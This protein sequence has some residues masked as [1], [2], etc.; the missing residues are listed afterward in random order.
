MMKSAVSRL[1]FLL[2][3]ALAAF[4]VHSPLVAAHGEKSQESFL[5][6]RTITFY[7]VKWSHD[8]IKVGEEMVITGKYKILENWPRQIHHPELG[9]VNVA[10][11]GPQLIRK[12]VW[13]NGVPAVNSSVW[14]Q[15]IGG[16]YEFRNVMVARRPG[17]YHMHVM[18]SVDGAG[19]LVGPGHWITVEPGPAPFRNDVK[20]L[21]GETVNLETYG[22]GRIFGWHILWTVI[23]LAWLAVWA[24]RPLFRRYRLIQAGAEDALLSPAD[25]KLG[26]IFLAIA[27]ILPLVG[28][29]QSTS[30]YPVT[31]PLQA[32]DIRVEPLKL[33]PPFVDAEVTKANYSVPARTLKMEIRITNN[34][35]SPVTLN[36]WDTAGMRFMTPDFGASQGLSEC[37]DFDSPYDCYIPMEVAP[38]QPV[39]PG[40]TKTVQVTV[41]TPVWE[42]HN[43]MPLYRTTDNRV[44]GL[45]MFFDR[46]GNRSLA[47]ASQ[48]VIPQ[49]AF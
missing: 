46:E 30:Q 20:L 27:I 15:E 22:M 31:I 21:S 12:E 3:V 43:L 5:R 32:P 36:E 41:T 29:F 33:P 23:A 44:G 26:M 16:T 39:N 11:P 13:V 14:G 19:P 35:S 10:V 8:R 37:T 48:M 9:F 49:F 6:Q 1:S 18:L 34:G 24:K 38:A 47:E 25:R 45:L 7:D 4:L 2:A 40:E 28:Y 42:V 17:R